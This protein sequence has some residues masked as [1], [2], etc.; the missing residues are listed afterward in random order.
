M[1]E[2]LSNDKGL[3]S[4]CG[5][6][7]ETCEEEGQWNGNAFNV[8]TRDFYRSLYATITTGAP[9]AV[10]AEQAAR[11]INVIETVHAQNPMPVLY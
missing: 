7:L 2:F 9:L 8:G 3:P 11:I 5:E 10:T 6:K 4:Y 1:K